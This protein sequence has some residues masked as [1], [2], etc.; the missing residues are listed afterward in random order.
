MDGSLK[1]IAGSV[2]QY[3]P[4][5]HPFVFID[6]IT[7][8]DPGRSGKGVKCITY[9]ESFFEGHFPSEPIFPGVLIIE[10]MAQMAA[11]V[12]SATGETGN[13]GVSSPKYLAKVNRAKFSKKVIPG[14][15]MLI[16][17]NVLKKMGTMVSVD[18]TVLVGGSA[19]AS[20][21]LLLAG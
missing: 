14:D 7:D 13:P 4:H 8:L 21:E 11:I 12:L 19:V 2:L 15:T 5:R 16:E 18:C 17:V 10:S 6:R 3:I 20:A 9:N 1:D